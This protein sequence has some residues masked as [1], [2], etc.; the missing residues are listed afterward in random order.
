MPRRDITSSGIESPSP[1]LPPGDGKGKSEAVIAVLLAFVNSKDHIRRCDYIVGRATKLERLE[2]Y[3]DKDGYPLLGRIINPAV[4][5]LE[6]NDRE[7]LIVS[8]INEAGKRISAPFEWDNDSYR[9][10]WEAM[11]GYCEVP[12]E[13]FL[14]NRPKGEFEMR[15]NLYLSQT[16]RDIP[17][18]AGWITAFLSHPDLPEP[19]TVAIPVGSEAYK[20]LLALPPNTDVPARIGI[21]WVENENLS[22]PV[23]A[24]WYHRDW[25]NP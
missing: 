9:L 6:M 19:Q 21:R 16:M 3:Y 7:I 20:Q 18:E 12:W 15:A 1:S 25:I 17:N 23:V 2:S 5:A 24:R 10:H 11:T 22:L 14:K 13:I 4:T 8:F